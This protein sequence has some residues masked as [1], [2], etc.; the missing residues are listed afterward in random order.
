[1]PRELQLAPLHVG[2]R[3]GATVV[4]AVVVLYGLPAIAAGAILAHEC[5]HAYIRLAGGYPRLQ[6]KVEEGLCQ[7]VALLWAGGSSTLVHVRSSYHVLVHSSINNSSD[8]H[9]S[10]TSVYLFMRIRP[11]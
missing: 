4:K 6:P 7:L 9:S 11:T 3:A 2:S 5:T 10:S 8:V 1:M